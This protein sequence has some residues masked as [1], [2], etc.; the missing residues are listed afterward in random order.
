MYYFRIIKPLEFN[1]S[2]IRNP[3]TEELKISSMI[4]SGFMDRGKAYNYCLFVKNKEQISLYFRNSIPEDLYYGPFILVSRA[5]AS[6]LNLIYYIEKIERTK[7]GNVYLK[8]R[9]IPSILSSYSINIDYISEED[10]NLLKSEVIF[11]I[12]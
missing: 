6:A 9:T 12:F 8:F 5:E 7:I 10:F 11:F 4:S 1:N 3:I 2:K